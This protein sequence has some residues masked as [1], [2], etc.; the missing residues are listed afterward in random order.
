MKVIKRDGRAVEYNKEKIQIAIGKANREVIEKEKATKDDIEKIINYIESLDKKR[1]L[2]EDIQDIIEKKLMEYGKFDLAKK[3]ILYRY[4]R[5]LVRKQNT[6][7]ESILGLI[8]NAGNITECG[9][10]MPE[11]IS[12]QRKMIAGEVSKDLTKRILLPEKI[13]KAHDDGILHFHNMEYFI[14]PCINSCVINISDMLDNGFRV[15]TQDVESPSSFVIACSLIN[16][17]ILNV[18]NNQYGKIY[19]NLKCLGKYLRKSFENIKLDIKIIKDFSLKE[20]ILQKLLKNVLLEGVSI[21]QNEINDLICGDISSTVTTFILELDS[22]DE[23][24]NENL[25]IAKEI[26][27]QWNQIMRNLKENCTNFVRYEIVLGNIEPSERTILTDLANKSK[28]QVQNEN[29]YDVEGFFNQG[30]VSINLSQIALNVE[31]KTETFWKLLDE[32]LELCYEALMCKHYALLGTKSNVSPIHWQSGAIARLSSDEYIDK[33][34]KYGYSDIT[35][36]FVGLEEAV[37]IL[38]RKLNL[39]DSNDEE[40]ASKI[41]KYLQN[42]VQMWKKMTGLDFKV[43]KITGTEANCRLYKIDK[44]KYEQIISEPDKNSY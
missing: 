35:L 8:K 24:Y 17:I 4:T 31:E 20:E 34:L 18:K 29:K 6:T 14:H 43:E 25:M 28:I 1:I 39:N 12:E 30:I 15:N 36:G 37:E 10:K 3:Y 41:I 27:I 19:I 22:A 23:Y 5:A 26:L 7:D 40:N 13:V 33:Y 21:F 32:R 9:V 44:D 11:T 2:V 38:S 16:H 42:K